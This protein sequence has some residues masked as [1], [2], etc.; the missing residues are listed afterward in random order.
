MSEAA[1][2]PIRGWDTMSRDQKVRAL[3]HVEGSPRAC[4]G[5]GRVV[6]VARGYW[7]QHTDPTSW[8]VRQPVRR[9][10]RELTWASPPALT[11]G[12]VG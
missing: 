1:I 6:H 5:C 11:G 4:P 3:A 7:T 2:A 10:V 9:C 8:P 12:G